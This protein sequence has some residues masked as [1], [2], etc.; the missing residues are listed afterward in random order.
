[1]R[2]NLFAIFAVFAGIIMDQITKLLAIE[3]LKGQ[4]SI[5]VIKNV[6]CLQYLENKGAA[7]GMMQNQQIFFVVVGILLLGITAFVYLRMPCNRRFTLMRICLV[8]VAAGAIGNMIDR[9]VYG[10]VV[11]FLY[12]EL[13]DFP[14]FNVADIYVT[15]A[16]FGLVLLI[17]FYYKEEELDDLYY[18]I[19]GRKSN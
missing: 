17:M 9:V 14:I 18:R 7:F 5:P 10:Y 4:P 2:K 1:M 16:A 15:V 19:T 13:I 6:F 8:M 11:D 3:H 12:F